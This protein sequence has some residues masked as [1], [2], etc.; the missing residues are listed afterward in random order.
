MQTLLVYNSYLTAFPYI[1]LN[2][3]PKN[4][5]TSGR[6][7]YDPIT[8][9]HAL[10]YLD[11]NYFV[12]SSHLWARFWQTNINNFTDV[13]LGY[14]QYPSAVSSVLM[15]NTLWISYISSSSS[16]QY[17]V[18]PTTAFVDQYTLAGSPLPTSATLSH[19]DQIGTIGTSSTV[20]MDMIRLSS[21]AMVIA[22]SGNPSK[23]DVI[24]LF[25][26]SP[27]SGSWTWYNSLP[28]METIQSYNYSMTIVQHPADGAVWLFGQQD[29]ASV[30]SAWRFTENAGSSGLTLVYNIL[31]F[32]NNPEGEYPH[33][34]SIQGPN[35]ILLAYQNTNFI[36]YC[37]P[38]PFIKGTQISIAH[39]AAD[40]TVTS[41]DT[42]PSQLA[43]RIA[44]FPIV[45]D[46]YGN[47]WL[48][49]LTVD[50][51]SCSH[52]IVTVTDKSSNWATI[53]LGSTLNTSTG[54]I[55]IISAPDMPVFSIQRSD[56]LY[57][58]DLRTLSCLPPIC[59][60]Q[61]Y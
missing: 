7:A 14:K 49:Y 6:M 4:W 18:S 26:R 54:V 48:A 45:R 46:I 23:P 41:I 58:F 52:T 39:I 5:D 51:Y 47:I 61:L 12:G 15:G 38:T 8:G 55:A 34:A 16:P 10:I 60:F 20:P 24:S 53:S 21:G 33:L 17:G 36:M 57:L 28:L 56:G 22:A 37:Y 43:E 2:I 31:N 40:G 50:P 30:T 29:G 35:E 1:D 25:Y 32:P 13:D 3:S 27:V 42:M 59:T 9:I 19:E 44:E 11:G